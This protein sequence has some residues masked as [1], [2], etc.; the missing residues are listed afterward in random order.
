MLL[1]YSNTIHESKVDNWNPEMIFAFDVLIRNTDRRRT[2]PN[3][4]LND[5]VPVLIDHEL[6]L[7]ITKTFK[8]YVDR[9]EWRFIPS[10]EEV[11]ARSGHVFYAHLRKKGRKAPLDFGVFLEYLRVLDVNVISPYEHQLSELE[12]YEENYVEI[13]NYLKEVKQNEGQFYSL[14]QDLL[15]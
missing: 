2:K 7:N 5:N 12:C 10:T 15:I 6:S 13:V 8:E 4:F 3:F 14:L 11:G 1:D 9:K